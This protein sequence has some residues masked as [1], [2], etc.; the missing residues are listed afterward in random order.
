LL[1]NCNC[2]GTVQLFGNPAA[3]S[4]L[5]DVLSQRSFAMQSSRTTGLSRS[6]GVEKGEHFSTL[7]RNGFRSVESTHGDYKIPHRHLFAATLQ[8][9]PCTSS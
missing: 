7:C 2:V 9:T 3:I 8:K 6:L 4:D 1:L 5:E